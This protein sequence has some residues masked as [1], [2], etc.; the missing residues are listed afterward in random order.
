[1][2]PGPNP[3]P[4]HPVNDLP[5]GRTHSTEALGTRVGSGSSIGSNRGVP[6]NVHGMTMSKFCYEC[7]TKYLIPQAKYCCECGT[8]RIWLQCCVVGLMYVTILPQFCDNKVLRE[9]ISSWCF[10][11]INLRL[12]LESSGLVPASLSWSTS[13]SNR[14]ESF[15]SFEWPVD[16]VNQDC[17]V[18]SHA[19]KFDVFRNFWICSNQF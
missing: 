1:M 8:K 12:V 17:K 15:K 5:V 2:V 7:G 11:S 14:F 9:Y 18:V 3:F 13:L 16:W 19:W 4:Q 10:E 6:L